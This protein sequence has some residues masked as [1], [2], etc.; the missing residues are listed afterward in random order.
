MSVPI[1]TDKGEVT[2]NAF[3]HKLS[4]ALFLAAMSVKDPDGK[5]L[6]YRPPDYETLYMAKE[7]PRVLATMGV[8]MVEA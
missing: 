6:P 2:L 5:A 1:I 8:K 7:L 4:Q 3:E